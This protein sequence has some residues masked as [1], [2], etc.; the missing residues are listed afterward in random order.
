MNFSLMTTTLLAG[1]V[2][3][4]GT[5]EAVQ[6]ADNLVITEA[7]GATAQ[8]TMNT[9][10]GTEAATSDQAAQEQ[11]FAAERMI[12]H[13]N[14]ARIA[15][16]LKNKSNALN[17]IQMAQQY[18]TLLQSSA[19]EY[20]TK[21]RVQ[22]GRFTY[23]YNRD[24]REHYY[25][26]ATGI[27]ERKEL[28]TGPF[29]SD[30]K[31]VAV[32]NAE[33]AYISISIDPSKSLEYLQKAKT[34][35]DENDF[36]DASEEL[37]DLIKASVE[38]EKVKEMPLVKAQDNINLARHFLRAQNYD[39]ARFALKHAENAIKDME[40]DEQYSQ[41]SQRIQDM[42][43]QVE[44]LRTRLAKKDPTMLDKAQAQLN[45]WW[46]ELRSWSKDTM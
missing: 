13:V 33:A 24:T 44:K 14:Y 1:M 36:N 23:E 39:G 26:I 35:L 45:E 17:H 28:D 18:A 8:T 2:A 31:G 5:P 46:Q 11:R 43:A 41:Q 38:A 3:S 7:P 42:H 15:A 6:V 25:P 37:D 10:S 29:W 27:V 9:G 20:R 22:S 19:P 40:G 34:E 30:Q 32:K 16:A 21:Q 12:E 4:G